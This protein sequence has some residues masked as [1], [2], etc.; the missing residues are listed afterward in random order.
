MFFRDSPL[1]ICDEP[2]QDLHDGLELRTSRAPVF[3]AVLGLAFLN[4]PT[5]WSKL[6]DSLNEA[7]IP[8]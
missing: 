3:M 8:V 1:N 2:S 6:A 5:Y 4:R 7:K